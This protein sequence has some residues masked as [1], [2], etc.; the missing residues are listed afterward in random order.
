MKLTRFHIIFFKTI[1]S[2]K[3]PKESLWWLNF[4]ANIESD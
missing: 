3:E 1:F 4:L 2:E